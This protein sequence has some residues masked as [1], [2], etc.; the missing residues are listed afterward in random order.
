MR[1]PPDVTP[2]TDITPRK[3]DI[4]EQKRTYTLITPLYGGGVK[5]KEIDPITVVRATEIRGLLRFWWRACRGWKFEGNPAK[6]KA[7]EAAIWGKAYEKGDK[8]I[9]PE[10]SIQIIVDADSSQKGNA[11]K[12]F[13]MSGRT[14][15]A[16]NSIPAY[17]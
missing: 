17:A 2:P 8:G 15:K 7:E 14:P 11:L 6:M 1:K 16:T 13:Y 4:I 5:V 3:L 9:P 10:Q 12:P